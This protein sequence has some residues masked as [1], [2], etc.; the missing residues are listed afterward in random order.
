[1][2]E[3]DRDLAYQEKTKQDFERLK[4]AIQ[5][6]LDGDMEEMEILVEAVDYLT[7]RINIHFLLP[8]VLGDRGRK[9]L[10]M[11]KHELRYDASAGYQEEE[12][13]RVVD[14][15][16]YEKP[17]TYFPT[18]Y[19]DVVLVERKIYEKFKDEE[20]PERTTWSIRHLNPKKTTLQKA[21]ERA[22]QF[23]SRVSRLPWPN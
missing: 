20:K 1:M 15:Y 11:L 4:T 21:G 13:S 16:H 18:K 8:D 14:H 12:E 22:R 9:V 2:V 10:E 19:E 3:R 17:P 5:P 6:V 23:V 7:G